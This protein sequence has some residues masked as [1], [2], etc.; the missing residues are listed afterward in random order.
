MSYANLME[1]LQLPLI[2][3]EWKHS[4]PPHPSKFCPMVLDYAYSI[5]QTTLNGMLVNTLQT[6]PNETLLFV[7]DSVGAVRWRGALPEPTVQQGVAHGQRAAGSH[8]SRMPLP[9]HSRLTTHLRGG[10]GSSISFGPFRN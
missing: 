1:S 7:C 6:E 3:P 9:R 8:P 5:L 2:G 10:R 4:Q